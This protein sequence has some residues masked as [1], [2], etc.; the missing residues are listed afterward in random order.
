MTKNPCFDGVCTSEDWK[1]LDDCPVCC[2]IKRTMN[3]GREPTEEELEA[4]FIEAF[5]ELGFDFF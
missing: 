3:E 5:K 4:A 1:L 2:L